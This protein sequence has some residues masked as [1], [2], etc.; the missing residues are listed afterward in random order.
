MPA[1]SRAQ[2]RF[3]K[4]IASGRGEAR[5]LSRAKAK[6]F[7]EGQSYKDLPEKK[8]KNRSH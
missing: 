8:K 7:T 2:F 4:W 5:G 3:M 1:T 6:E